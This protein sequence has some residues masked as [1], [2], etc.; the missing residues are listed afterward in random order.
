MR[1]NTAAIGRLLTRVFISVMLILPLLSG[2]AMGAERQSE[3]APRV[4]FGAGALVG[5]C[6]I[7]DSGDDGP[8]A[9]ESS[10]ALGGG[11]IFEAM[12][13]RHF[14][15]HSGLW[16][17]YTYFEYRGGGSANMQ[18]LSIPFMLLATADWWRM[19]F[20]LLAGFNLTH[21]LTSSMRFFGTEIETLKYLENPQFAA[22]A[23]VQLK[24]AMGRFTDLFVSFIGERGITPFTRTGD[25]PNHL[26]GAA[27]HSGVLFRTF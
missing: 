2:A 24:F 11:L 26:Y 9:I 19:S 13:S 17:K 25:S 8:G 10:E 15:I 20:G 14:G 6:R 5:A 1:S 27:V 22:A 4:S 7:T 21:Y 12:M 23:G 3:R 18:G 16:Y